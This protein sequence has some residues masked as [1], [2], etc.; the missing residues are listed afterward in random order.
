MLQDLIAARES[1]ETSRTVEM[2]TWVARPCPSGSES[3]EVMGGSPKVNGANGLALP[4][5]TPTASWIL[6]ANAPVAIRILSQSV[7]AM[8]PPLKTRMALTPSAARVATGASCETAPTEVALPHS[9]QDERLETTFMGSENRTR[10]V[11]D[12]VSP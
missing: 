12:V 6:P 10:R 4:A 5:L 7:P 9:T 1:G 8:F 3:A 11:S 2:E